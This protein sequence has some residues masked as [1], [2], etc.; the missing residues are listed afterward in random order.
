MPGGVIAPLSSR[1]ERQLQVKLPDVPIE[2]VHSIVGRYR[3]FAE[4]QKLAPT[5]MGVRNELDAIHTQA[6]ALRASLAK[7]SEEAGDLIWVPAY[8]G[9][10]PDIQQEVGVDLAF[11]MG[12]I[13]GGHNAAPRPSRGRQPSLETGVIGSLARLLKDVGSDAGD[14][15]KGSPLCELVGIVF[16]EI[17]YNVADVPGAVEYAI[18]A[19]K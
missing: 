14:T 2:R 12:A 6:L 19:G 16:E 15:S 1:A 10:R 7:L 11:L 8:R 3:V 18:T 17:G 9:G 5:A 13:R 4:H